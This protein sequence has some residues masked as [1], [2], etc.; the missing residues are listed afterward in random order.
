MRM[1]VCSTAIGGTVAS[2]LSEPGGE[3]SA[4]ARRVPSAGGAPG[5]GHRIGVSQYGQTCQS[6]SS[7]ALQL[8][9]ACLSFVVQT[10]Q[11]RKLGSTSA[12]QTGQLMSAPARRCLDR[13]DLELPLAPVVDVLRRAEEHVDERPDER[14]EQPDERRKPDEERL[15][16]AP[17]RVAVRPEAEREPEHDRQND[18][19]VEDQ[20]S[21]SPS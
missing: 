12:W 6:G 18:E 21:E 10:G 13:A 5:F 14:R 20:T 4:R 15:F 16:D 3:P 11:T 19:Q 7:G 17:L 2:R 8:V 9:H 1:S